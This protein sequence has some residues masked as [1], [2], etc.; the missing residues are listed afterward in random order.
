MLRRKEENIAVLS[1][2]FEDGKGA[3]LL[4]R[5]GDKQVYRTVRIGRGEGYIMFDGI[6]YYESDFVEAGWTH[7]LYDLTKLVTF[8]EE[9]NVAE[10]KG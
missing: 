2:K 5:I 10:Q 4:V 6:P 9:N 7:C 1:G 3:R 8:R